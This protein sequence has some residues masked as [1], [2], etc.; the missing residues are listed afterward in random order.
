[1]SLLYCSFVRIVWRRYEHFVNISNA[2]PKFQKITKIISLYDVNT[3]GRD[4]VTKVTKFED[5]H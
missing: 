1:M 5:F 2:F 4:R 3:K